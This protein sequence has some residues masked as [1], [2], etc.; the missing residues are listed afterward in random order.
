MFH[1]TVVSFSVCDNSLSKIANNF[2]EEKSIS[3]DSSEIADDNI[4][5]F[6][7]CLWFFFLNA[8]L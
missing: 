8:T 6:F 7:Y 3:V 2:S 1:I 5:Q 4:L